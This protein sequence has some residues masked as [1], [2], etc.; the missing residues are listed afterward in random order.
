MKIFLMTDP[1]GVCGVLNY[2]EW[3]PPAS[4]FFAQTRRLLTQEVN[5]AVEGFYA[6]GATSVLVV[7]SMRGS[8]DQDILDRRTMLVSGFPGPFPFGLDRGFDALA[9]VG[10]HAKAGAEHA[11]LPHTDGFDVLDCRIN[12]VS[13]GEL[14]RMVMCGASLGVPAIFASGDDALCRE[15]KELVPEIETASVKRGLCSETGEGMDAAAYRAANAG[16]LHYHP[17]KAYELVRN[18]A[19]NALARF[20]ENTAAFPLVKI[21]APFVNEVSYRADGERKAYKAQAGH[22]SDLIA[23]LNAGKKRVKKG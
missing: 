19:V 4:P 5:A 15:A 17:Q 20:R 8:M 1:V 10:Q 23:M 11:H 6:A 18:G 16:A 9:F 2:E 7:D 12:G 21:E 22:P 3:I 14:G 13:V